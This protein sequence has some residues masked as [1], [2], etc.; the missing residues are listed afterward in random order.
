MGSMKKKWQSMNWNTFE[1]DGHNIGE[2]HQ[3]L[4]FA[5]KLNNN[6]SVIIANTTKGKGVSFMENNN[7]WHQKYLD[8]SQYIAALN[9]V[10]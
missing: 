1:I 10:E 3:A 9:E 7:E 8:R 2:I 6:P 5:T 4:E